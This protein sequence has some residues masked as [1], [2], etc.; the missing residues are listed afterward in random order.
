M[1]ASRARQVVL[2]AISKEPLDATHHV[3]NIVSVVFSEVTVVS[4]VTH[5]DPDLNLLA[6]PIVVIASA[7]KLAI[8]G[9]Q[10]FPRFELDAIRIRN[11]SQTIFENRTGQIRGGVFV[12]ILVQ[13]LGHLKEVRENFGG[14]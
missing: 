8:Q 7:H 6:H 13:V 3:C 9:T 2:E 10:V 5:G 12:T 11:F 4:V 14:D 1:F